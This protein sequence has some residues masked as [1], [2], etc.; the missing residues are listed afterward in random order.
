MKKLF[1][2]FFIAFAYK[3]SGQWTPPNAGVTSTTLKVGIGTAAPDAQTEI[4]TSGDGN[5][6]LTRYNNGI[7]PAPCSNPIINPIFWVRG[8]EPNFGGGFNYYDLL[9]INPAGYLGVGLKDALYPLHI[10][11]SSTFNRKSAFFSTAPAVGF[12]SRNLFF[13]NRLNT[14]GYNPIQ[15]QNDQG[16]FWNDGQKD[17]SNT[18][19][20]ACTGQ[21]VTTHTFYNN[22]AG[23]VIAPEQDPSN[24]APIGIRIDKDGM[25]AINSDRIATGYTLSVNGKIMATEMTVKLKTNWPDYVFS[26]SYKRPSLK[27]IS[28]YINLNKCL[29]GFPT[30]KQVE[31]NGLNL[32]EMQTTQQKSLEELYLIV[33]EQ[34]KQIEELKKLLLA[35]K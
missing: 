5:L 20:D 32:A 35:K 33:I 16:I 24:T 4:Y 1:F 3:V 25:V 29:P 17:I 30:A 14:A 11:T 10:Q 22:G 7:A 19:T 26:T 12:G 31:Q 13:V 9:S 28:N 23:F 18:V 6:L 15:K 21:S 27:Y 34:Q 8:K 2:I